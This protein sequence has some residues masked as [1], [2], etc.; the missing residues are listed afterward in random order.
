VRLIIYED[1]NPRQRWVA[2]TTYAA[3]PLRTNIGL[4]QLLA[5]CRQGDAAAFNQ[6]MHEY[7]S[8]VYD[9]A[10]AILR[11]ETAA[12]DM[13]QE[14]FLRVYERLE[15]FQGQSAF[16]TWLLAITVNCCRDHLRRRQL[17]RVLSLDNLTP[18]W[19]RRLARRD[20]QPEVQF[21]RSQQ[22]QAL[23][24]LINRLD[25]RLRLTLILR[26]Y[27]EMNCEEVGDILGIA[28]T[29]VYGRLSQGRRRLYELW[30]EEERET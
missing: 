8:R 26:Y 4:D 28:T 23:W 11:D 25:D 19:L 10:C 6:L 22:Q 9:L 20:R 17:R 30:Q 5:R 7:Q 16:E 29:T 13:V 21:E 1:S 3:P 15:S 2:V 14:T 18:A 12:K 27:Y 24:S